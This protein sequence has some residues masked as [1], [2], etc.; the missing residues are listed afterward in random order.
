MRYI[1]RYVEALVR[2]LFVH[3]ILCESINS[4]LVFALHNLACTLNHFSLFWLSL[5]SAI[6]F[7][8][9]NS[10]INNETK[11]EKKKKKSVTIK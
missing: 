3:V 1:S 10:L 6:S 4:L 9:S 5:N 11:N 8:N 2:Y 7:V